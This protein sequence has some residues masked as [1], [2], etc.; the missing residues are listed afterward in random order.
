MGYTFNIGHYIPISV[1]SGI[2]LTHLDNRTKRLWQRQ[3]RNPEEYGWKS[4]MNSLHSGYVKIQQWKTKRNRWFTYFIGY[5][6]Y[7]FVR[8]VVGEYCAWNRCQRQRQIITSHG[9]CRMYLCV[10]VD[11]NKFATYWWS[12]KWLVSKPGQIPCN[13]CA[14]NILI[15]ILNEFRCVVVRQQAINMFLKKK[16]RSTVPFLAHD[17]R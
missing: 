8:G 2:F 6:W 9:I 12:I 11:K 16:K 13:I 14:L 7:Q 17:N 4:N 3:W 10:P 15:Y 5:I 1:L